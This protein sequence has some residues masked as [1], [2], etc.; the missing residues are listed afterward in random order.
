MNLNVLVRGQSNAILMMESGGWAG[1]AALQSEVQRLLGFDGVNETVSLVYDRYDAN[2]STAVGGTALIGDWLQARDGDWRQG[3]SNGAHEQALLNRVNGLPAAQ[4]DDPTA[5]LWMHS[6]YDSTNAALTAEQWVSAVRFDAQ[7]VRAALGQG[8]ETTPYLFV[9]AM[10]YWGTTSGHNAIRQGMEQLAA[11]AGF[12]AA[13]AARA[14]D[15]D[16]DNDDM[17]GNGATR[18]YGGPH[19]DAEDGLQTVLRA[20]RAIAEEFAQ[21]ARPGSPVAAAGG[22]IADAGPQ[23]IRAELVGSNQLRIDVAHDAAGGFQALDADAA[24]GVGWSVLSGDGQVTGR[25]VSIVDADTLLVTFSGEVAADGVLHYGYGYGRLAGADGSGRGNAV[26]DDAGLPIWVA[27]TGLRVGTSTAPAEPVK[28]PAPAPSP[29]LPPQTGGISREGTAS[30]DTLRG[31]VGADTLDGGPGNDLLQG[32]NRPDIL[33]GGDGFDTL[34]GG[35]GADVLL[36]GAG[37]DALRGGQGNDRIATG[38]GIDRVVFGSGD[39]ADLVSDFNINTDR[40]HL[41]GVTTAQ[42]VATVKTLGGESGLELRLPGGETLFL[43]GLGMA[44]PAQLGLKGSFA[45]TSPAPAPV[46][47]SLPATASTV[48]GTAGDDWLKGGAGAELLLGGDGSDDLQG[49]DG[50][51]VLRGGR[52]HDGLTGGAGVDTFAFARGDGYDWVVDF[53]PGIETIWL[54]GIT[55]GEV[56]QAVESRWGMLGLELDFGGG[57]EIFLQGVGQP[58][59]TT[60]MVFA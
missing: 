39:G 48:T 58:I 49:L 27:A 52:D 40:V 35:G 43:E 22:N 30:S 51:D 1:H 8:A 60:D 42:V 47:P 50:D 9:S 34:V 23:V 44:T 53:Q 33:S 41:V 3:W 21:Y 5:T 11:E 19:M 2:S 4:K 24:N 25:A 17:D 38:D 14:L 12:N 45:G 28:A 57:D 29:A 7:Q 26:Y 15:V 20:A 54:E 32:L 59:A 16:I 13:I 37:N 36:G 46:G 6:E 18:D 31:N 56:T 10:P 55:A